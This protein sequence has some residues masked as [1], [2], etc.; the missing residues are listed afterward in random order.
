[1][2]TD[3]CYFICYFR[4]ITALTTTQGCT[5]PCNTG[6]S[7]GLDGG[8]DSIGVLTAQLIDGLHGGQ[9][10]SRGVI[11]VARRR[12][13]RDFVIVAQVGKKRGSRREH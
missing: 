3:I 8:A 10:G 13:E 12:H 9:L 11:E 6:S 5:N 4:P 1:M 2:V 7:L